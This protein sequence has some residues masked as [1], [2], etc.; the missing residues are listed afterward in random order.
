MQGFSH[1][2]PCT[3]GRSLA[4]SGAPSSS[5]HYPKS[6]LFLCCPQADLLTRPTYAK[7]LC[8][9]RSAIA[10]YDQTPDTWSGKDGMLLSLCRSGLLE[11]QQV[12]HLYHVMS[13]WGTQGMGRLVQR[14]SPG[15][16]LQE[17][18]TEGEAG[19]SKAAGLTGNCKGKGKAKAVSEPPAAAAKVSPSPFPCHPEDVPL[20]SSSGS[21]S[22]KC[23]AQQ[24]MCLIGHLALC[25]YPG[26]WPRS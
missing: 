2:L 12:R 24:Q 19:A 8:S 11:G 23:M 5:P 14:M 25:S 18:P 15:C 9:C 3:P 6:K 20:P 26:P 10:N 22:D 17:R 13:A 16:W 21:V 1:D 4:K 7:H